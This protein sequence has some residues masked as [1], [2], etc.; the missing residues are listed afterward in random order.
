MKL[1]ELESATHERHKIY[2]VQMARRLGPQAET[3]SRLSRLLRG[4]KLA[5]KVNTQEDHLRLLNGA[6]DSLRKRTFPS[7]DNPSPV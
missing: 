3:D 2:G 1:A 4:R 6:V 7:F 5:D